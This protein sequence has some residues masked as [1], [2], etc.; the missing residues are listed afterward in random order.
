MLTVDSLNRAFIFHDMIF[1]LDCHFP[2]GLSYSNCD[3]LNQGL[4]LG[5]FSGNLGKLGNILETFGMSR[6]FGNVFFFLFIF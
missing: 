3:T 2:I 6:I 1:V 5:I 4:K